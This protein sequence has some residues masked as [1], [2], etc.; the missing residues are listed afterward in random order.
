MV[1]QHNA[2]SARGAWRIWRIDLAYRACVRFVAPPSLRPG[3]RVAIVAPSSP[4]ALPGFWSGLSWLRGR[5]QLVANPSLLARDGF[6]AGSDELRRSALAQAMTCPDVRAIVAARGGYGALRIAADLPWKTFEESP[7]WLVGFSDV[8]ALHAM[9]WRHGVCSVH[10]PNVTGLS[11]ATSSA[12][13]AA[14]LGAVERPE[15]QRRW[16]LRTLH[17]GSAEGPL[18]GGNLALIEAMA[19]ARLLRIARGA[20][21]ALEDVGER[22]YR[23]DRML[24]SL[25]VGGW[26]E[27]VSAIVF[28]EFFQCGA[29]TEGTETEEVLFERTR[30]LG[31]PVLAGAPFGHGARN[32]AFVL[33]AWARVEPGELRWSV[34][35]WG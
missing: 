12:Q 7:K 15:D 6:L 19:S 16:S 24:T 1:R 8:T 10:G 23:I 31:I 28:G 27:E 18:V 34:V 33:G 14:W 11:S 32:D 22:P 25:R 35:S 26:L 13:R 17:A 5:Y 29:G 3:D 4:F 9:A 21:V 2:K 20:V 30:G